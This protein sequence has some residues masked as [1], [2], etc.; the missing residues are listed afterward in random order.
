MPTLAMGIIWG[1]ARPIMTNN[2]SRYLKCT[3]GA[4]SVKHP[5]HADHCEI[6]PNRN[7]LNFT[8]DEI[9]SLLNDLTGSVPDFSIDFGKDPFKP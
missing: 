1:I 6:G 9:N 5:G 2:N 3:C 8:E 7:P 4:A